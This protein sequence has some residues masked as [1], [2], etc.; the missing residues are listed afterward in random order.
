MKQ[1]HDAA[2]TGNL[3]KEGAGVRRVHSLTRRGQDPS[4]SGQTSNKWKERPADCLS[5]SSKWVLLTRGS[6]LMSVF[7]MMR[8]APQNKTG[9]AEC[10]EVQSQG[11]VRTVSN[12]KYNS[13]LTAPHVEYAWDALFNAQSTAASTSR[14]PLLTKTLLRKVPK[15]Q[16]KAVIIFKS[17]KRK[18]FLWMSAVC[19]PWPF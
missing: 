3:T 19:L 17:Q 16:L 2:L 18:M 11:S 10:S 9:R 1:I 5:G 6:W 7:R 4:Q 12:C 8:R 14:Q 15:S 13:L